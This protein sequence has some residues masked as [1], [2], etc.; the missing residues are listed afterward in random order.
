MPEPALTAEEAALV[1]ALAAAP[2]DDELRGVYADWLEENGQA[3][4]A[5]LMRH[6]Q[7]L[8]RLGGLARA[9]V[10]QDGPHP[11]SPMRGYVDLLFSFGLARLGEADG[12][13]EL[14]A[15]AKGILGGRDEVHTFL[16]GAFEY[17]IKQALE[18]KPPT[19][20]L[21]PRLLEYLE[22]MDRQ[23]RYEADRVRQHSYILEPD[24]R[25]DPYRHWGARISNLDRDLAA[26][27]DVHD[28]EVAGRV[29]ALLNGLGNKPKDHEDRARILKA[30]LNE[31][32]RVGEGFA[33]SLLDEAPK[34][35]DALPEAH[36]QQALVGQIQFLERALMVAAH[37]NSAEAIRPL[38][39]RFHKML[40]AEGGRWADELID[41]LGGPCLS[42][43]IRLGLRDEADALL[44]QMAGLILEG[45]DIE[46]VDPRSPTWPK[47][48]RA[49]LHVAG[50]RY[51]LGSERQAEPIMEAA[52]IVLI[53]DD[54][55][56]REKTLLAVNY[57]ATLGQAPV[58]VAQKRLEELFQKL[59]GIR[60]TYTTNRSFSLS[61]LDVIEA[62]VRAAVE[63]GLS[64]PAACAA[65]DRRSP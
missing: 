24:G 29:R 61:Q 54:L 48:L 25:I 65:P 15:R 38:V 55:P 28:T 8:R 59:A 33:R 57:A 60:D 41:C 18:G 37:F 13:R 62:V 47:A 34:A 45:R 23:P 49:L 35:F 22:H 64:R 36:D 21:P 26:L 3:E 17:R 53:R 31:A 44:T 58:E 27:A 50:G 4:R 39:A 11:A 7:R 40:R 19:G 46:D 43:L 5:R 6:G 1:Q 63:R 12:S 9:W 14:L 32:P 52:R 20:P 2:D 56:Y 51:A 16:F 42:G 10:E 30:G